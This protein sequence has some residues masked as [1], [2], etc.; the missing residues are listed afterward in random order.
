MRIRMR[1]HPDPDSGCGSGSTTLLPGAS[2]LWWWWLDF[3]FYA[4]HST[5]YIYVGFIM[6]VFLYCIFK[7]QLLQYE[8]PFF[9]KAGV[10]FAQKKN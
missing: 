8:P 10:H 9:L 3:L 2:K 5:L 6:I 4:A 1:I 7:L